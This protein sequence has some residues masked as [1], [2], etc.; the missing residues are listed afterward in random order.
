MG[1]LEICAYLHECQM[2]QMAIFGEMKPNE[3]EN[4]VQMEDILFKQNSSVMGLL[5]WD[6]SRGSAVMVHQSWAISHGPSIMGYQSWAV[7]R[8]P[9]V[10]GHQ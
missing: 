9:S 1:N 8:G 4:L 10:V 5:S 3:E 6:I 2:K 7:S